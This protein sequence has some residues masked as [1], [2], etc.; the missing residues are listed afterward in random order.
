MAKRR[1]RTD[2]EGRGTGDP[3]PTRAYSPRSSTG[4]GAGIEP[5][6]IRDLK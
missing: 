5:P 3:R 6:P 2:P 4:H 1:P